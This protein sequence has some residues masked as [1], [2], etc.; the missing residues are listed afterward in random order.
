MRLD[1]KVALISGGARGMGGAEARLF[2]I[3]GAA[4]VIGDVRDELGQQ[5]E[6]EINETG[7]K[8]L[9]VHLRSSSWIQR[10]L[11]HYSSGEMLT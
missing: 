6:A 2:A 8:A 5:V 9:Y 11:A 4:V 1:G 7:G 3:E 10:T